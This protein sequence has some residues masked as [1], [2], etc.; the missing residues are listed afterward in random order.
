MP[1]TAQDAGHIAANQRRED[2]K[3][4]DK[5][6]YLDEIMLRHIRSSRQLVR[7]KERVHEVRKQR[8]CN[9]SGDHERHRAVPL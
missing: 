6:R 5:K 7:V 2:Y 8:K 9:N 1:V 3:R 4:P